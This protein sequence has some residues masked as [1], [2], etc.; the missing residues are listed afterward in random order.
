MRVGVVTDS[1]ASLNVDDA[2][3]EHIAIVPVSV[4]VGAE[5][6]T[7]GVDIDGRDIADALRASIPVSTSRPSPETFSTVYDNLVSAGVEAICSIHLSA[8]VSGTVD[9][10]LI[11]AQR[12]S[13]PVE[14]VD[15]R[16]ISLAVGHAAGAAA[17]MAHTGATLS[18]VAQAARTSASH[19]TLFV[20]VDTLEYLRRGGR[21]GAAA[22]LFGSVLA[23]KPI[24]TTCDGEV[25]V[26][27][28]VRTRARALERLFVLAEQAAAGYGGRCQIGV[29]HLDDVDAAAALAARLALSH[30]DA[31]V[32]VDELGA[33]LGAHAGPGTIAV[34]VTQC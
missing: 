32:S 14:V 7:Q 31:V 20:Y 1:T 10:A 17:R 2:R 9:S 15:T 25:T 18:E 12:C 23:V 19:S 21:I 4:V 8:A 34:T 5:V 16:H 27:D 22:S 28:R 11:A 3:R 30:P 29:Q 13:V 26:L 24:L 33:D 6:H